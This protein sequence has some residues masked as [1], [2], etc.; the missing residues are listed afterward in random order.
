[1]PDSIDEDFFHAATTALQTQSDENFMISG[2]LN[3]IAKILTEVFGKDHPMVESLRL[4]VDTSL[5]ASVVLEDI[6]QTV[7]GIASAH[8]D[9]SIKVPRK[10]LQ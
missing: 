5:A 6:H 1:M 4:R 3:Q 9:M 7:R 8:C 10:T 2:R